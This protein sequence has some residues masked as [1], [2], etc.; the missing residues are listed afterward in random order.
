MAAH[1]F[2]RSGRSP[3]LIVAFPAGNA[4]VGLWFEDLE[5][6][7][8]LV[9]GRVDGLETRGLRGIVGVASAATRRL[10]VRLA[11]LGS[12]RAVRA[13]GRPDQPLGSPG[14][15]AA[16]EISRDGDAITFRRTTAG[17]R[18]LEVALAPLDGARAVVDG[19]GRP[20]LRAAD[21]AETLRFR[22]TALQDDPPLTPIAPNEILVPGTTAAAKDLRALSFLAYR[23]KLLAGSWRFLTYFGRDTLLS[24]RLL[25]PVLR[26]A[27]V[28]AG[29]GAVLERV[30]PSG[31]VA[32]EED[33]GE[34]AAIANARETE[35]TLDRERP[36]LDYKMVDDDFLLAPVVAS[37]ALQT[38]AGQERAPAL[39]ARSRPDGCTFADALRTNL[40]RVLTLAAPFAASPRPTAM[41]GL[42]D[43]ASVG[44]WRDS[45]HGLGGGRFAYDVN[46]ALVPA[47]L[48]AAASLLA[49]PLL[50][51]DV[52]AAERARSMASAWTRASSYFRVVVSK[53]DAK[54]LIASYADEQGLG[55]AVRAALDSVDAPIRFPALS[56]DGDGRP[57]PVMHSDHGFQLLFG[58]PPFEDLD[59]AAER[60][61]RPFPAGLKTPVGVVVANPAFAPR[62]RPLFGRDRYHGAVVW[63]W[64]QAMLAAGLDR[65]LA[66]GD[67]PAP[68]RRKLKR[69]QKALWGVIRA[70]D[71]IR[72]SELWT[73]TA[74]GDRIDLVPFGRDGA[75]DDESN[76]VQLWSTVY[77]A[78]RPPSSRRRD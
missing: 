64:Q 2:A 51:T 12:L 26:P 27:V 13:A 63:S 46:V 60:V 23:E 4:G 15:E 30:G 66:R 28:E 58:R 50:G 20:V 55:L 16:S 36:R 17:G 5:H 9:V 29:L 25:L 34:W 11:V 40:E 59:D 42:P 56:L 41:V 68:M 6:P 38:R 14:V 61:L 77:L 32:H 57:I 53:K 24:L 69:A 7:A 3:R 62:L 49:S 45:E 39:L 1:V 43:G 70:A 44:E 71:R 76:A 8:R 72:T 75:H 21:D 18:H 65:Q 54:A 73:W 78:V 67:L 31:E 47:A 22:M 74:R 10:G 35:P 33:V 19:H 48:E 37:W 52:R